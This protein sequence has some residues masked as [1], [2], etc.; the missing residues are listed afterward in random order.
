MFVNINY[1]MYNVYCILYMSAFETYRLLA[2]R[3]MLHFLNNILTR[4]QELLKGE[5]TS[6]DTKMPFKGGV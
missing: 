3:V 1:S 4:E 6:I 5:C 2:V